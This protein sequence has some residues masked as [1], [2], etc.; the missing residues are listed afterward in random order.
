MPTLTIQLPNLPPVDHII[1]D[2]MIT[3]G[4]MKGNTIALD[5]SSVSISHAKITRSNGEFFVKDLNSTNGTMLNGQSIVEARLRDG[6]QIKFGEVIAY[7]HAEPAFAG[8]SPAQSQPAS[9]PPAQSTPPAG[10]TVPPISSPTTFVSKRLVTQAAQMSAQTTPATTTTPMPSRPSTSRRGKSKTSWAGPAIGIAAAVVVAVILGWMFFGGGE[11]PKPKSTNENSSPPATSSKSTTAKPS[12]PDGL[13]NQTIAQ[14]AKALKSPNVT[15]RRAA[16]AELHA[17]GVAAKEAVPQL[18]DA[19]KDRDS[20]VRMWAALA[21]INNKSYDKGT[22]PILVQTLRNSDP[23][24][25]QVACLSL[26]LIPYEETEKQTV[27]P[28]L[29]D[30]AKKDSDEEVRNAANSAL[31]IISP[32]A[33]SADK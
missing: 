31:R 20:D 30:V 23:M 1:R 2:E 29:A 26:A 24:L 10:P 4:R 11:N 8:A 14:L 13:Q 12:A 7:Y 22:V 32:D 17:R 16:A 5:D 15:E 21:L 28:P 33:V 3:I 6:D 19:I 27:V 25:R 9:P 18:R